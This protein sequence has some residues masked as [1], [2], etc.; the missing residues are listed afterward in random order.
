MKTVGIDYCPAV[1]EYN[2]LESQ[3]VLKCKEAPFESKFS[4]RIFLLKGIHHY[5]ASN[6]NYYP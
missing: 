2:A 5:P 6:R 3:Y 1:N 4:F